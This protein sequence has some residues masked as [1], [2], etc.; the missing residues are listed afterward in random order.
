MW[1]VRQLTPLVTV[2]LLHRCHHLQGSPPICPGS[3]LQMAFPSPPLGSS[4]SPGHRSPGQ[5][6]LCACRMPVAWLCLQG[7]VGGA[8]RPGAPLQQSAK[9]EA[10]SSETHLAWPPRPSQ[11]A[12]AFSLCFCKKPLLLPPLPL[13]SSLSPASHYLRSRVLL[14]V[15][16]YRWGHRAPGAQLATRQSWDTQP[17]LV[18]SGAPHVTMALAGHSEDSTKTYG[19]KEVRELGTIVKAQE[20][21]L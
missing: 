6:C 8:L 3:E 19:R 12:P 10:R 14:R 11:P 7:S 17:Y 9:G 18:H 5:M 21:R 13:T 2:P 15:P 4:W 1:G 20:E 16:S